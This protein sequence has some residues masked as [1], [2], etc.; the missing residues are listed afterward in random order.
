MKGAV[1]I[2]QSTKDLLDRGLVDFRIRSRGPIPV[3]GKGTLTTYWLE[4]RDSLLP[5][6]SKRTEEPIQYTVGFEDRSDDTARIEPQHERAGEE[7]EG[8]SK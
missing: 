5:F 2:S 4:G 7:N 3:K 1:Q 8:K 6:E